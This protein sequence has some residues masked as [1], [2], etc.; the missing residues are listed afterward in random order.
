[1][2][3][4][5]TGVAVVHCSVAGQG[6]REHLPVHSSVQKRVGP[7]DP[8]AQQLHWAQLQPIFGDSFWHLKNLN[9]PQWFM[10]FP[11]KYWVLCWKMLKSPRWPRM[12]SLR[13]I[14]VSSVS[15]CAFILLSKNPLPSS[16]IMT[17]WPF[18]ASNIWPF[19]IEDLKQNHGSSYQYCYVNT[20]HA[21][22]FICIYIY[23]YTVYMLNRWKKACMRQ[24]YIY[25][26]ISHIHEFG[27]GQPSGWNWDAHFPA[28]IL[29]KVETSCP[30]HLELRAKLRDSKEKNGKNTIFLP[31]DHSN[32]EK[33]GKSNLDILQGSTKR[34]LPVQSCMSTCTNEE[35]KIDPTWRL[36]IIWKLQGVS[37]LN[38]NPPYQLHQNWDAQNPT[39]PFI[40]KTLSLWS[41]SVFI[42]YIHHHPPLFL[43]SV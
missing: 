18:Q 19:G 39:P 11:L 33:S 30:Q 29:R 22:R 14:K 7:K 3:G 37:S 40:L 36:E 16:L 28:R 4:H 5:K 17:S 20:A 15:S 24:L 6:F 34:L 27:L 31:C 13:K 12:T 21:F 23:I 2:K 42:P 38:L 10:K 41:K 43:G 32:P 35:T 9:I 8:K 26:Y 25:I 1:M